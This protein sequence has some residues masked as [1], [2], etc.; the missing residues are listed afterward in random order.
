MIQAAMD[1]QIGAIVFDFWESAPDDGCRDRRASGESEGQRRR[2]RS[3]AGAPESRRSPV[4][5]PV[6]PVSVVNRDHNVIR[7]WSGR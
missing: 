1:L 3:G 7:N 2:T 6:F 5:I 4:L